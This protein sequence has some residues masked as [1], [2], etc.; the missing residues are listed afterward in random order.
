MEA[1]GKGFSYVRS[2]AH[3]YECVFVGPLMVLRDGPG[4]KQDPRLEEIVVQGIP[5]RQADRLIREYGPSRFAV[6]ALETVEADHDAIKD[7]YKQM[8]YR[9]R[10][11]EPMFVR[12]L[13]DPIPEAT[14]CVV[15][16][17]DP[18]LALKLN[19]A[20]GSRQMLPEHLDVDDGPL[21]QYVALEN[22]HPVGWVRSVE[23]GE[24]MRWVSNLYVEAEHRRKGLASALMNAMLADDRRLGVRYSV[25]LASNAG[26]RL[27]PKLGY[28]QIGLLQL[29]TPPRDHFPKRK[30]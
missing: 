22:G 9:L 29:F 24:G 2:F 26:S 11:R 1:F 4:K 14:E 20:V 6:S 18:E 3:P 13:L 19:R 25:L 17:Q 10:G 28:E 27:Y 30:G 15:R 8:G 5:P 7:E 23:A 12:D 21:R 16:V